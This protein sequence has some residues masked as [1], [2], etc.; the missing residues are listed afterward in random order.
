MVDEDGKELG[1]IV[2]LYHFWHNP[3]YAPRKVHGE[4][5]PMMAPLIKDKFDIYITYKGDNNK[6]T[7]MK[8]L[9][10][11]VIGEAIIRKNGY[12]FNAETITPW[13]IVND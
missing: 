11:D 12:S 9:N 8:L 3:I 5:V 13:E 1:Y 7:V 2:D 6:T 10:V 4:F